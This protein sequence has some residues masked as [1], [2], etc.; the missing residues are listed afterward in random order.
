MCVCRHAR[1][2]SLEVRKEFS[3]FESHPS[4]WQTVGLPFQSNCRRGVQ[5]I[6]DICLIG[7]EEQG[8]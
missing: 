7:K 8:E 1:A 2:R 4:V 5:G 6:A 3:V